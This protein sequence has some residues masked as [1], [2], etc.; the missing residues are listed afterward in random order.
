MNIL[1]TLNTNFLLNTNKKVH[2]GLLSYHTWKYIKLGQK[3]LFPEHYLGILSV[4]HLATLSARS[5]STYLVVV[6]C[7]LS[8]L[9]RQDLHYCVY[10][11]FFSYGNY[12]VRNEYNSKK[13]KRKENSNG[14]GWETKA[15]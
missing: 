1:L 6:I 12:N 2:H 10:F 13:G 8:L 7:V 3:N 4:K 14:D 15:A 5:P 11:C 9:H